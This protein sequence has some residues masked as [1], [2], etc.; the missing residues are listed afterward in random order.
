[1]STENDWGCTRIFAEL[2]KLGLQRW[3]SRTTVRQIMIRHGFDPDP[4]RGPG[5]WK[6]FI[7]A[8]LD[9]LWSCDFF[10]KPVQTPRGIQDHYVLFFKHIG[11]RRVIISG[12]TPNP[13]KE[14]TTQ[15]ARNFLMQIDS[16]GLKATHLIRD[17]DTKFLGGFDVVLESEDI[18]VVQTSI[19]APEMNGHAESFVGTIKRECLDHFIVFSH[20]HLAHLVREFQDYYNTVRPHRGLDNRKRSAA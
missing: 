13:N 20:E 4:R 14:W 8:H 18:E 10:T 16:L 11:S 19:E 9:T 6:D 1:M 17:R 5:T 7:Q 3:T 15:Q 12:A 2:R